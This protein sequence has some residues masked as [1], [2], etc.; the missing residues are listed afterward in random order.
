MPRPAALF[1]F[2]FCQAV[3]IKRLGIKNGGKYASLLQ[4]GYT[5]LPG[6]H[7]AA[8]CGAEAGVA[9]LKPVLLQVADM[10]PIP[11]MA[12]VRRQIPIY[13]D[14]K[15]GAQLPEQSQFAKISDV[16]GIPVLHLYPS[17]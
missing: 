12:F 11:V 10:P 13:A 17:L 8:Q 7:D 4:R 9:S 16:A 5:P 1:P 6:S 15:P 14:G 2:R 3:K